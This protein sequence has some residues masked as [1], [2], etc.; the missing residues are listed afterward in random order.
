MAKVIK[1][2]EIRA[3][4]KKTTAR[5]NASK[6]KGSTG[7]WGKY[8]EIRDRLNNKLENGKTIYSSDFKAHGCEQYDDCIEINGKKRFLESKTG[9]G[10]WIYEDDEKLAWEKFNRLRNSERLVKWYWDKHHEPIRT[11]FKKL[12]DALDEYVSP[13]KGSA[14][15]LKSWIRFCPPAKT[16]ARSGQIQTQTFVKSQPK[17]AFLEELT[18]RLQDF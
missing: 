3:E 2:E 4:L 14:N 15:G 8:V 7:E 18:E 5:L 9:C 13:R 6:A 1:K 17:L 11:T 12:F 10:A 16:N